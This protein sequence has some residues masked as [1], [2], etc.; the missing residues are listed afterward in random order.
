[1]SSKSQFL[2]IKYILERYLPVFFFL[3]HCSLCFLLYVFSR[4]VFT[5]FVLTGNNKMF[6]SNIVEMLKN[7]LILKFKNLKDMSKVFEE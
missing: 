5:D 2:I 7:N 6:Y 4:Y 3:Y 1:M